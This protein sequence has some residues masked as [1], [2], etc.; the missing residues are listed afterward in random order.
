M[1]VTGGATNV[2]VPF[3]F[4]DD[5][6]GTNPG[7]P[8]TGLLFSDIE[9]GG[10]ASYQRQGAARVDITAVTIASSA[11]AHADGSFVLIDDTEMPGVY[12]FDI[13][14]AAV[15]S[16]VDF[17]IIYLRAASGKNTVTRPLKIDLTAVDLRD[18][19][20]G[21]MTAM[22]NAA[23]DAAGG[24]AISDAGGLDLDTKLANTN[25]ITAARMA[26]LT[27][28]INGGRLDL[29][30]DAIPT[31]A[32]RGTDSAA[33]ASVCTEVRLAT[34]TDWINGGRLDLLLDAIPTTAMRGTDSAYTGTPPTVGAIA[35]QV[36]DEAQ[37]GHTSAGSF[38]VI[39]SEIAAIPTTAMRGTDNAALASV[40]TEVR[41]AALTDWIDGGRLDLLLDAILVDTAEIGTAGV[42][43][44]NITVGAMSS[45]S[46]TDIWS[47]DALVESYAAD[48]AAGTPAQILYLIQQA[49]TEF[50]ITSTTKTIKKVDGSTTAATETLDDATAPTSITRST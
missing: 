44:S 5:V 30:L 14:D 49:I 40:C 38:G 12:R 24:L 31:T 37:S 45:A 19:V 27:D 28:W 1:I 11:T 2:S 36:W 39:A 41:L 9:T 43:L 10:S 4:V 3:Y 50:A 35:D 42:G 6:G 25:E 16:G 48:G 46:V 47:T 21:G 8:T 26:A 17:V 32:M 15:A 20:R 13:P 7:E 18:G 29:L 33:L 34:L 23:A 22:P